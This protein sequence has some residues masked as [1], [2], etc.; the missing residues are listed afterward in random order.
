LKSFGG[1][2]YVT[3]QNILKPQPQTDKYSRSGIYQMK[4][5][6]CPIK[7]IGQ[8]GR[9]FSTRYKEHIHGIRSNN[10]NTEYSNRILNTGHTY[11]TMQDTVEIITLGKKGKYLNTL[12]RYHIYK[13]SRDNLSMNDT[14]TTHITPYSKHYTQYTQ[15]NRIHTPPILPLPL[16]NETRYKSRGEHTTHT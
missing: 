12:E 3:L 14:H 7:Y 15:N 9:T 5:M 6:D 10:S 16:T 8:T 4:C 2:R 1:P 13:V 11:G